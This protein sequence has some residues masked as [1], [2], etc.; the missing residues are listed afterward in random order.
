MKL[1]APIFRLKRQAKVLSRDEGIP[2]HEAQDRI[3]RAE[4]FQRWSHLAAQHDAAGPA[5][6]LLAQLE[7][8]DLVLLAGKR[9]HGKTALAFGLI[10]EALAAD[11]SVG[12]FSLDENDADIEQRVDRLNATALGKAQPWPKARPMLKIAAQTP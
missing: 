10:A 5:A 1:S 2:L 12:Y 11:R 9:E 4:G 3:A 7:P 8:G 6:D